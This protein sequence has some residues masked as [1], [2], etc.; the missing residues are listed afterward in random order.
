MKLSNSNRLLL[1]T[2]LFFQLGSFCQLRAQSDMRI[3]PPNWWAGMN[4]PDLQL[5]V[6]ASDISQADFKIKN[7]DI[8]LIDVTKGES[9]N[10]VFLDLRIAEKATP[11]T[12]K[13]EYKLPNAKKQYFEYELRAR[14]KDPLATINQSDVLYLV[15]PDRFVNGNPENDTVAG[16]KESADRGFHGG[17]HGGD[18]EGVLSKLDYMEKLG[19][20][21][22]W[23]NPVVENDMPEYSYHGYAIT[24][25]Y[26]VDPR[27][28]SNELY[29]RLSKELHKR[30][31]KLVMDM[32]F[33]HSGLEHW[34]M[35]DAPFED[36]VHDYSKY[37][38]TNFS[39][40]S[41]SDPYATNADW[42][43][44]EKGWFVPSMPDLNHDNRFLANYLIQNSIW[45]IEYADLDGIRMDTHPYNK[46]E[47]M[48]EWAE[49]VNDEYPEFY[50][51]GET[52]VGDVSLEAYW[53]PKE[54]SSSEFN[55]GLTSITDFP[56]CYA[57]Q[58]AFKEG[59]NV[60]ELYSKL[61]QDFLYDRPFSNLTFA[62]N[63]DM[64]RFFY[65]IGKDVDRFNL[66]MTFLLTTRG[67]PQLY[68]GTEILMEKFGQHGDLREDFPG[69][70]ESDE[71]NAFEVAN[72]NIDQQR[73]FIHIQKLLQLRKSSEIL[74]VG[75]LLHFIPQDNIYVYGR[76]HNGE[77][78][79]VFLNNNKEEKTIDLKR[80][81]ELLNGY[82][83]GKDAL[84]GLEFDLTQALTL[85][86]RSSLILE[87]SELNN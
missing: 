4:N 87:L 86:S 5:L 29:Q 23:L 20:T 58:N 21:A 55:S 84:S 34:W 51:L 9:S 74:Q 15:T 72:L 37:E 35:K 73:A 17:R 19:I 71:Q 54:T 10:Y 22:L 81:Y 11:Q 65:T 32:V 13:I 63:H 7:K 50:L 43:K 64:D 56:L 44:M 24:D 52:W 39:I 40:S 8:E 3:E 30:D 31:M 66:A 67:I 16:M 42:E 49:R 41:F 38:T 70:W 14:T 83:K 6:G 68:Y 36:W 85:P 27:Y 26:N 25:F 45:W 82:T 1:A 77:R 62:D 33:N 75:K 61:S 69:G 47:V 76:E 12:F 53:S 59:G 79:A 46:P 60:N 78:L 28:G 48:Q 18:L 57:V 2:A 80:F